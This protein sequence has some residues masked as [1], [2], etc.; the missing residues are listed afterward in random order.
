MK[1]RLSELRAYIA[2][3]LLAEE[4]IKELTKGEVDREFFGAYLALQKMLNLPKDKLEAEYRLTLEDGAL[5]ARSRENAMNSL[6]CDPV[7][8][9]WRSL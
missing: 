6:S 8:M 5:Y 4:A 7:A 1:F 2:S 9:T 3:A